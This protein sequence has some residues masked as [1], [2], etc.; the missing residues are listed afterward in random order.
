MS[1]IVPHIVD[2][3]HRVDA[4][5]TAAQESP[6]FPIPYVID[7]YSILFAQR[8]DQDAFSFNARTHGMERFNFTDDYMSRM[9]DASD[10]GFGVHFDFLSV[11]AKPWRIEAM[12]ITVPACAPL[13]HEAM[14]GNP[15]YI[16][17]F[18]ASYKMP[19]A[20]AY[21][22]ELERLSRLGL[23]MAAQY[24]NTYGKFSYWEVEPHLPWFK[25]RCNL[26]DKV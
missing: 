6:D 2:E 19:S 5:V 10:V 26:R 3:L 17:V 11:P 22:E 14:H 8:A 24:Q 15:Q 20:V 25:P 21:E 18:H 16:G 9:D 13:H 1:V 23:E 12:S 7:E 4:A